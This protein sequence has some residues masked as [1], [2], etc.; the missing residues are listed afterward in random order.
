M[1]ATRDLN[2]QSFVPLAPAA[3][4]H[5]RLP[6]TDAVAA[7]VLETRAQIVRILSGEDRRF[8]VI[9]GPCSIHD[10]AA[11]LDYAA[12]LRAVAERLRDELL[13]LMRVYFEKPRT[14][15]G[16]KGL[17]YDPHLDGTRDL[18]TGLYRA[19]EVLLR[20]NELG[21]T[22]ATEFLDPFVPQYIAD[23]VSWAA[24]GART[25]ESQ[26]HRQMASGLSMPVGFKNGTGGSTQ[27]AVDAVLAARAAH[28]FMGVD[29]EGRACVVT[30]TGNEACHVVLRGGANG[31]NHHE[32]DVARVCAQLERA[33]LP[34]RVV[35]DCSHANSGKDHRRQPV[36]FR[37][38]LRQRAAGDGRIVG[39]ML[40]SHLFEG[41]Q[42]LPADLS[43]LRYGVSMTDACIGWEDTD[44]LLNE[45]AHTLR[46][47]RQA[48]A[49][50]G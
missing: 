18:A 28:S 16:W 44:T 32:D 30:T 8:L 40:E 19:R 1:L 4:L 29:Y 49:A 11:A 26:T 3:D 50:A 7:L 41:T 21:L 14:T 42:P 5:R 24:I 48:G 2:I 15:T 31:A 12:R 27:L 39:C 6:I 20:V 35:V 10:P 46:S 37:E 43:A 17:I 45:A 25:A 38:V 36:V 22:P 34:Q 9:V 23:L 47:L 33:G 13:I